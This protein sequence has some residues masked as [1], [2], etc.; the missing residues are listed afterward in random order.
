MEKGKELTVEIKEMSPYGVGVA[1][2][3]SGIQVEVPKTYKNEKVQIELLEKIRDRFPEIW[4]AVL[5]KIIEPS[6]ERVVSYCQH[7]EVCQGCHLDTIQYENQVAFKKE[8]AKSFFDGAEINFIEAEK[9]LGYR[10]SSTFIL[11]KKEEELEIGFFHKGRFVHI[12]DCPTCPEIFTKINK[13][14]SRL[15][16]EQPIS[17]YEPEQNK[18]FIKAVSYKYSFSENKVMVIFHTKNTFFKHKEFIQ[19]LKNEHPEI[20]SVYQK[21][22]DDKEGR[23]T[24]KEKKALI[25]KIDGDFYLVD[26]FPNLNLKF[27]IT[28]E[29]NFSPNLFQKEKIYQ[30]I[31]QAFQFKG[32]EK[33]LDLFSG[34]GL[35][36]IAASKNVKMVF[37][38][39]K[40]LSGMNEGVFNAKLN[41]LENTLFISKRIEKIK[42]LKDI[43]KEEFQALIIQMPFN[44]PLHNELMEFL[45]EKNIEKIV[46][47]S[48]F[49]EN[50][51]IEIKKFKEMGY[52]VS[53]IQV[54]DILPETYHIESVVIFQKKKKITRKINK[55]QKSE[56]KT[57]TNKKIVIRAKK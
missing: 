36:S 4:T 8:W 31:I 21:K 33:L 5:K 19:A 23:K 46:L 12:V 43:A 28:A 37:G 3:N 10:N 53:Q 45:E 25:E 11:K 32:H 14:L 47:V 20:V 38:I 42:E 41:R 26:V 30:S 17:I 57:Q 40:D 13:T 2:L 34:S 50:L 54:F 6:K 51:K 24:F 49:P 1:Y 18:G 7:S 27:Q 15:V 35:F 29:S 9:F 39:E 44:K 16:K 22:E 55:N 52:S 48:I 56:E